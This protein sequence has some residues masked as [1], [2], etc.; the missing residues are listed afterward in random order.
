MPRT[1][2]IARLQQVLALWLVALALATGAWWWP[3]SPAL[4]IVLA[5]AIALGH[6]W[7]L[8]AE[9]LMLR[10]VA[11]GD[12]AP[13]ASGLELLRAW[14]AECMQGVRVFAWRQ[15]FR[16]REVPDRLEGEGVRGRH[17]VVLVHGFVCNRGFWT[18]WLRRLLA[19]RRAFVAVNLEPAFGVI[20]DYFPILDEAVARV[21]EAT[22]LPPL[23]VGHSM[24]GLAAR[25]WLQA[26]GDDG[27]VAH[28]V[29]LGSP[30]AGTWIARF[31]HLPN[32]R[33][34]RRDSPWIEARR[35]AWT[36]ALARRFTCWYSNAD[37]IVMPPSTATLPG[38]DNRLVR[39]AAHVQLAFRPEVMEGTLAL[40]ASLS[41]T[42]SAATGAPVRRSA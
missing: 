8:G 5:L 22:G 26:R 29:T 21:R 25:A 24:G 13:R 36:P 18:P 37:N 10:Q 33:Q 42:P 16:W 41:A 12:L 40:L 1:S 4:A 2:S 19:D 17:G 23:L 38:A 15:P 6:A 30:H 27:A 3:R 35:R 39:G 28:V 20:D 34:M 31:S 7:V 14:L 32:G 11:A 9:F